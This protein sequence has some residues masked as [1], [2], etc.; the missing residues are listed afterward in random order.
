ML[1]FHVFLYAAQGASTK[2]VHETVQAQAF[3]FFERP[4]YTF[5]VSIDSYGILHPENLG[6]DA[7]KG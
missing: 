7:A 1:I 4:F 6:K 5:L 3:V 2:R